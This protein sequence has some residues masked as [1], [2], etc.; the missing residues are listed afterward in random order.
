MRSIVP[1]VQSK[2]SSV[3]SACNRPYRAALGGTA[4]R[5]GVAKRMAWPG[6]LAGRMRANPRKSAAKRYLGPMFEGL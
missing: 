6:H 1:K 2:Q 4:G 5:G 3:I